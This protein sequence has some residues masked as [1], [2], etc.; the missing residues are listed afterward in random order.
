MSTNNA[1]IGLDCVYGRHDAGRFHASEYERT[2]ADK[3]KQRQRVA[4]FLLSHFT[5]DRWMYLLSMPGRNWI[6]EAMI[7]AAYPRAQFVGIERSATTFHRACPAM[8]NSHQSLAVRTVGFGS[9]SFEYAR[10]PA[11][12]KHPD[13]N[14]AKSH[15]FLL[16]GSEVYATATNDEYRT[17]SCQRKKFRNKFQRRNAAWLDFTSGVCS[18]FNTT[19]ANLHRVMRAGR[20]PVA[21]TFMFGRDIAGRELGRLTHIC[22]IQPRFTPAEHWVYRGAGGTSMMTVCGLIAGEQP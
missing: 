19:V 17:T 4:D 12:P 21:L 9:G 11:F 18:Q 3:Q 22:S 20:H 10:T 15:R 2:S 14:T 5:N 8:V 13:R 7:R 6:F 1:A 16:M